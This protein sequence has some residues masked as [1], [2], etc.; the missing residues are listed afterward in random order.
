MEFTINH[1]RE[2]LKNGEMPVAASV[3]LE[4][5][6][7]SKAYT[8]EKRDERFLV[9]AELNALLDADKLKYGIPD[10]KKMA[11]YTT[12]EPCIMCY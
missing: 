4:D 12:L 5:K 2:A 3:F 7:I 8:T 6:L 10:R 9:H 11:L 1:A